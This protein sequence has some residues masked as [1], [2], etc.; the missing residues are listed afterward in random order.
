MYLILNVNV[1]VLV[2]QELNDLSVTLRR[3]SVEGCIFHLE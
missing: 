3:G 1:A 2:N